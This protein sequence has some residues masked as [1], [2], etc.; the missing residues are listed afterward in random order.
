[1]L[2]KRALLATSALA[3]LAGA[4]QA[5]ADPVYLSVFGGA[6]FQHSNS[7]HTSGCCSFT[8]NKVDPDTGFLIGAE[9]GFHFDRWLH[10]LR[11]GFEASYRRN[12]IGGHWLASTFGNSTGGPIDVNVS[13]FAVM[14]NVWYDVDFGRKW[15]PYFGGGAGW[16]RTKVDGALVTTFSTN[17]GNHSGTTFAYEKSGFAWQLGA[18]VN[19]EIQDGVSLGLGYRYFRGPE[20]KNDI[21]IGKNNLPVNFENDNHSVMINLTIET[22]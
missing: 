5:Q 18:G 13:T 12:D 2:N 11:G 14:A 8:S 16:A 9:I 10:G 6:N 19:Y 3:V 1:M 21:F 7:G 20:I 22:N 17:A 4:S 15:K